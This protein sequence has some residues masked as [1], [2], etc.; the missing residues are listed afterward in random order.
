MGKGGGFRGGS[1][2][3][4]SS[5]GNGGIMGSGIFGM[6]GT[7]I[8]CDATDQS[9]YCTIMKFFNLF[10]MILLVFFVLWVIYQF[11]YPLFKRGTRK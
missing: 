7:T 3:S 11:A 2:N 6:F 9:M 10:F 5:P 4:A 1:Q 8:R